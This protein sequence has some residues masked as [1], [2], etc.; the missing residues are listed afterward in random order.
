MAWFICRLTSLGECLFSTAVTT[1]VC[2][3]FEHS[4]TEGTPQLSENDEAISGGVVWSSQIV[5]QECAP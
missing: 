1:Q 2:T 4:V 5:K 3:L